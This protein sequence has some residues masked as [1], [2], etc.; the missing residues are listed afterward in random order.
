MKEILVFTDGSAVANG[1]NKGK[2][3]F[4]TYF[5]NFNNKTLVYS[6]G[7]ENTKT[8]RMEIMGLL[9]AILAFNKSE[10]TQV[11]LRVF[12]D[13]EYVI[14]SFTENRLERWIEAGWTNSSGNVANRDLWERVLEAIEE[15]PFLTL[16]FQHIKSHQVERERDPA[17]KLILLQDEH[18]RGN[19]IAD[20]LADYRRHKILLKIEF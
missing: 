1:I 3:G 15:R 12:S 18:I 10:K 6:M 17:K 16:Q 8:G 13:S 20:K 9:F 14:K 2:G 7:F 19:F 5:P 4:G 11:L